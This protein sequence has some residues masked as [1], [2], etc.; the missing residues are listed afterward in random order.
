MENPEA[1]TDPW[2]LLLAAGQYRIHS[3]NQLEKSLGM[4]EYLGKLLSIPRGYELEV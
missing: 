4:K 2:Q 3:G 1:P